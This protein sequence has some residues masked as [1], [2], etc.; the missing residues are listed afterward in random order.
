MRNIVLLASAAAFALLIGTATTIAANIAI[1]ITETEPSGGGAETLTVGFAGAT[2]AGVTDAW[3]ITL[4]GNYIVFL[5]PAAGMGREA[6][7]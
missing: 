1:P 2:I 3:K 4:P 7:G 6:R 5:A